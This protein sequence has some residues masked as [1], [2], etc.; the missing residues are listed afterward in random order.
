[1]RDEPTV[2]AAKSLFHTDCSTPGA[3]GPLGVPLVTCAPLMD[4]PHYNTPSA[5]PALCDVLL[6]MYSMAIVMGYGVKSDD[7]VEWLVALLAR[8][9]LI[10]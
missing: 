2:Q 3:S 6:A 7:C 9:Q 1:V 8:S 10:G 4:V 5:V